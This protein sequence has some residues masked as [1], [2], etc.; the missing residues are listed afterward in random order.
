MKRS[1]RLQSIA[2]LAALRV[3]AAA[4]ALALANRRLERQRFSEQLLAESLV[5]HRSHIDLALS[6]GSS[7]YHLKVLDRSAQNLDRGLAQ[8]E[9]RIASVEGE[10]RVR[11]TEW[12]AVRARSK[13]IGRVMQRRLEAEDAAT[14]RGEEKSIDD[15]IAHS[16][17]DDHR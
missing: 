11:L 17:H 9:S 12:A 6:A 7:A 10:R 1:K 14:R 3:R 13:A 4:E 5:E 16:Y 2:D 15:S 8:V